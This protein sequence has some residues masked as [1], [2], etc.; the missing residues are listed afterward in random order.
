MLGR[1]RRGETTNVRIVDRVT[2]GRAQTLYC[3]QALPRLNLLA[4]VGL[5][6]CTA[7]MPLSPLRRL[8]A[9]SQPRCNHVALYFQPK[10]FLVA[11]AGTLHITHNGHLD[12]HRIGLYRYSQSY[13]RACFRRVHLYQACA[14]RLRQRLRIRI[15]APQK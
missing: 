10:R 14:R 7:G 2:T 11:P 1:R 3:P 6:P 13:S 12:R 5:A 8:P 4:G 15:N 9:A